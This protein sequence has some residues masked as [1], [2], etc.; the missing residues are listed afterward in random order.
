MS[1]FKRLICGIVVIAMLTSL[2]G[3]GKR[4]VYIP[5]ED[6]ETIVQTA[7]ELVVSL[8][9]SVENE[10][11][12]AFKHLFADH[13]VTMTDFEI[14]KKYVFDLYKGKIQSISKKSLNTGYSVGPGIRRADYAFVSFDIVTDEGEYKICI[15]FYTKDKE[16]QGKLR[17][18]KILKNENLPDSGYFADVALRYGIYY[19]GWIPENE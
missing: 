11:A 15:E 14:G 6:E 9:E 4:L 12:E 5:Q 13:V 10:D 18:M 16:N 3:C 19:P 8:L 2:W 7:Q 17:R 1:R